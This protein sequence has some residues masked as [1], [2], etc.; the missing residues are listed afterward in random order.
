MLGFGGSM[1][2]LLELVFYT[3]FSFFMLLLL[4]WVGGFFRVMHCIMSIIGLLFGMSIG[5]GLPVQAGWSVL[6]MFA[7]IYGALCYIELRWIVHM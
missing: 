7:T 6:L 3:P 2:S 4:C 1:I 5:F